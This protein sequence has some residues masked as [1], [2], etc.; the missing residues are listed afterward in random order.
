MKSV[1]AAALLMLALTGQANAAPKHD[2]RVPCY[3]EGR[4]IAVIFPSG[5]VEYVPRKAM[6]D[7]PLQCRFLK[8]DTFE[9]KAP[10][11][12]LGERNQYQLIDFMQNGF[13]RDSNGVL[14]V[15]GGDANGGAVPVTGTLSITG[16]VSLGA[17]TAQIGRLDQIIPQYSGTALQAGCPSTPNCVWTVT[18]NI[19]TLYSIINSGP[20]M[21]GT[22]TITIYDNS[23]NSGTVILPAAQFGLGQV[24]LPAGDLGLKLT[25]NKVTIQIAGSVTTGNIIVNGI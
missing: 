24:W 3:D 22:Q 5:H 12:S 11:M 1:F 10:A 8:V 21:V 6:L 7:Y 4:T 9:V 17:G 2:N 25:S 14:V 15:S 20:S 19:S 13:V 18:T 16:S 23:T